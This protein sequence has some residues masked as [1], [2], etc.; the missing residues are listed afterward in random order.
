MKTYLRLAALLIVLGFVSLPSAQVSSSTGPA[1]DG[2]RHPSAQQEITSKPGPATATFTVNNSTLDTSD[3]VPGDGVC[4]DGTGNCTLRAAIEEANALAGIDTINFNIAP[5]GPHTI[6]LISAL[7]AISGPVI[8]NGTTQPGF[9]G[10]PIIMLNA[11]LPGSGL[12][13]I[14]ASNCT[15][16]GLVVGGKDGDGISLLGNGN[17]VVGN[18]IGTDLTGTASGPGNAGAGVGIQ[19]SGNVIGGPAAGDA[20][21]IAFNGTGVIVRPPGTSNSI[22]SNSIF[23]HLK[24]GIDLSDDGVNPNDPCDGDPG[25]NGLLNRPDVTAAQSN[26]SLVAIQGSFNSSALAPYQIDFYSNPVCGLSGFGEGQIFIGSTIVTTD[27][28]CNASFSASFSVAVSAGQFITATATDSSNSTSEFS[29]CV[30]V[31]G[32]ACVISCSPS[33][34]RGTDPTL[35][36]AVVTYPPPVTSGACGAVA[37]DPP[38]GSFFPKGTTIVTCSAA[39]ATTCAFGITV[40]DNTPPRIACPADMIVPT[41]PDMLVAVVDYP[42]AGFTDNCPDATAV[43]LPPSGTVFS[44]GVS[45]VSCI[46]KDLAG[47]TTSCTFRVNVSDTESPLIRCPANLTV[48]P[49]TGQTSA[50][51]TYPA[52]IVSDNLPGATVVCSPSSGSTFPLGM[53]RVTCT[54]A[55]ARGNRAGCSFIVIVGSPEAKVTILENTAAVEFAETKPTRKAPKPKNRSCELFM[56]ENIGFAPLAFTFDSMVRTGSDVTNGRITDPNDV[57][58]IAEIAPRRFF[59]LNSVNSDQTLIPLGGTVLTLQ[60]R[61]AQTFCVQFAAFIPALAGKTTGL[62]A[63]D[64]LPDVVTSTITFRQNAGPNI[65]IPVLAHVATGVIFIDPKNP[66]RP[67]V[68]SF[69]RSSNDITVSYAL[70]DSN[71]DVSRAKYEFLSGNGQVVAGPFE[72]DLA[73]PLRA[74]NLTRGQ[75]FSV[76]QRFTGASSNPEI[77]AVRVTVFDGETSAVGVTSTASATPIKASSIQPMYHRR[78]VTLHPTDMKIGLQFQ[79]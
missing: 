20:N 38:S 52:P 54:A 36:G 76:E 35:C 40:V 13:T 9:S 23:S 27:S 53:T 79:Q 14:A 21:I 22:R 2:S 4:N 66:R 31:I 1:N 24:F 57:I 49:A 37:C 30:T 19:G 29:Q 60:P 33:L 71:L 15:I 46:A 74:L 73:E 50:V 7:P 65:A 58:G 5:S 68:V 28:A 34:T 45:V 16:R 25:P 26:G 47:N 17:R 42:F 43:C 10:T 62:A 59:V 63:S 61:Q 69:I 77:T 8:I 78:G 67:P 32:A 3:A 44:L 6:T 64:V 70:F 72:I 39:A 41:D 51:A 11:N 55:D 48:V 12:L 56:I 18:F 75:S